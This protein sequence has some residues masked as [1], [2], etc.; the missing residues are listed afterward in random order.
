MSAERI[1]VEEAAERYA[2]KALLAYAP[3]LSLLEMRREGLDRGELERELRRGG[4]LLAVVL[5]E[6]AEG[7]GRDGVVIHVVRPAGE[8]VEVY[9]R[10]LDDVYIYGE[11]GKRG[12][13]VKLGEW[14]GVRP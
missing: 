1:K 14:P 4:W 9:E 13:H 6:A 5:V 2:G 8:E 12:G 11:P 10:R 3:D 7:R